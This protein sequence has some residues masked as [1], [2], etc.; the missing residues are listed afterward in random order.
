M[1]YAL[2]V[3]LVLGLASAASAVTPSFSGF[4]E[5]TA[6]SD[7]FSGPFDVRPFVR[8]DMNVAEAGDNWSLDAR[9]RTDWDGS[10]ATIGIH[11]YR[12]VFNTGGVTSTIAR[13]FSLGNVATP[14]NWVVIESN[15]GDQLRV[16]AE[17]GA[18]DVLTQLRAGDDHVYVRAHADAGA[19]AIGAGLAL[20]LDDTSQST[21]TGY[22]TTSVD[23]VNVRAIVGSFAQESD[24][25]LGA[26]ADVTEQLNVGVTYASAKRGNVTEGFAVDGTFTEGL[27]QAKA[28]FAEEDRKRTA[29][30]I[31]RG[32]E[33]NQTFGDLFDERANTPW[34]DEWYTNVAAAFGVFYTDTE[35]ADAR[36]RVVGVA[37]A[38]DN[39][40]A[41]ARFVT[42]GDETEYGAEGWL[43]VTDKLTLN[44]YF[45]KDRLDVQTVGAAAIY[46]VAAEAEISLRAEKE[47]DAELLK[48]TYTIS[49]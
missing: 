45:S 12:G 3:V 34:S 14:F 10:S 15:P 6:E 41:R 19:A 46:A 32:S 39:F 25:A 44:P 9:L 29:S 43:T 42:Q 22:I 23:V 26:S 18:V 49:F 47:G 4:L 33:D 17:A 31:Y 24:Y 38:G 40:V 21:Y 28:G 7:S 20:N 27:L 8:V 35:S 37:P 30:L 2:A 48:A 36:L 11:R 16:G 13:N 5:L 1:R